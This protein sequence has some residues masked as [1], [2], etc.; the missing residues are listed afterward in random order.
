MIDYI[1]ILTNGRDGPTH[2]IISLKNKTYL[3]VD[4]VKEDPA[5]VELYEWITNITPSFEGI[6][7]LLNNKVANAQYAHMYT[8]QSLPED[9][10]EMFSSDPEIAKLG[11]FIWLNKQFKN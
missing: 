4:M 10:K 6:V 9:C 2:H 5:Q 3:A 1:H 8:K 11:F 7:T